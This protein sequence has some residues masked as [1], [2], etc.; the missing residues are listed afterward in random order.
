[1]SEAESTDGDWLPL[2]RV[3]FAGAACWHLLGN[4]VLADG[5]PALLVGLGAAAVALWPRSTL[6]FAA[7]TASIWLSVWHE[8]PILG[9][10]WLLAGLVGLAA[11]AG[12]LPAGRA[13]VLVF[14]GFAAFA[15]LNADFFDPDVSCATFYAAESV[16]SFGLDVARPEG[17]AGTGLA[18]SVAV[19][20]LTVPVLLVVRRTRSIGVAVAVAFHVLLSLDHRHQFYDFTS[21]LAAVFVTFLPASAATVIG[22]AIRRRVPPRRL[23]LV[24]AG[25]AVV[26]GA[27]VASGDERDLAF[28]LGYASWQLAAV[29]LV[30]AVVFLATRTS[31]DAVAQGPRL[32]PT[33]WATPIVLLAVA[34]G[35]SP[36]LEL[37]TGTSWNMYANLRTA[38]GDTNHLLVRATLPIGEAHDDLVEVLEA[39]GLLA[40]YAER[41]LLLPRRQ[42]RWFLQHHPD[43]TATLRV[44]DRM[45]ELRPGHIPSALGGPVPEVVGRLAVLRAVRPEDETIPCQDVFLP[46]T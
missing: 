44:G 31:S 24:L 10:H 32:R 17:I 40:G 13:V 22:D 29:V 43:E 36:Y 23:R 9:N 14:Y 39:D 46:S 6:A 28:E 45:V 16:R 11:C 3:A 21:L 42:L 2:F 20:E 7:L 15:K 19:I 34:N 33:V 38:D 8:A 4:P 12:G 25:L 41:G 37:K 18:A 26:A 27:V 1:L 5:I 30:P 35:L